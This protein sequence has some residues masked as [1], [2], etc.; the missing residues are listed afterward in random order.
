MVVR[1]PM[2]VKT[3]SEY[4][5]LKERGKRQ[6]VFASAFR[7]FFH[8]SRCLVLGLLTLAWASCGDDGGGGGENTP[9]DVT[10]YVS[11]EGF[12][13]EGLPDGSVRVLVGLP[14]RMDGTATNDPDGDELT[15]SWTVESVPEGSAITDAD[16]EGGDTDVATLAPDVVGDYVVRFVAD[17]SKDATGVD[18]ML[19]A[20]DYAT[21]NSI[22]SGEGDARDPAVAAAGQS[23]NVLVVWV[24]QDQD[25][26]WGV[27]GSFFDAAAEAWVGEAL[28]ATSVG[29]PG[30]PRVDVDGEGNGVAVWTQNETGVRLYASR[31]DAATNTWSEAESMENDTGDVTDPSI[32]VAANGNAVMVWRLSS[33]GTTN[34]QILARYYDAQAA[35]PSWGGAELLDNEWLQMELPRVDIDDDGRAVAVWLRSI[36]WAEVYSRRCDELGVWDDRVRIDYNPSETSLPVYYL[37][38]EVT[39][40]GNAVALWDELADDPEAETSTRK[41]FANSFS[42]GT[43]EWAD[44]TSLPLSTGQFVDPALGLDADGNGLAVWATQVDG[45]LE[46][47]VSSRFDVVDGVWAEEVEVSSTTAAKHRL[48]VDP[49]GNAFVVWEN[50]LHVQAI[51]YETQTGQWS[52]AAPIENGLGRVDQPRIAVDDAGNGT[53]VWLQRDGDESDSPYSVYSLR[54]VA[55][56]HVWR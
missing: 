1:V 37:Q 5:L 44:A 16:L 33:Q 3:E 29:E 30:P 17:D 32:A 28:I 20:S 10:V 11:Q 38:V 24:Q 46:S 23:G 15:Y 34:D 13:T 7:L 12:D 2:A 45:T 48:A 25:S 22:E 49:G 19:T 35:T 8:F 51:R 47:F 55:E 6:E 42:A 56:E 26:T 9:P 18:V 50:T 31:Y 52:T 53:A 27:Y 14:V 21:G 43:G 40:D 4:G 54:Y 41:I 36:G 39:G